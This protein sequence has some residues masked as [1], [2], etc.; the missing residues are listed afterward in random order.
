MKVTLKQTCSFFG[1]DYKA[2]SHELPDSVGKEWFFKALVK[3]GLAEIIDA[4]ASEQSAKSAP[5]AAASDLRPSEAA[6]KATEE[7]EDEIIEDNEEVEDF[8]DEP[9]EKSAPVKA[10]KKLKKSSKK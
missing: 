2:G 4:K 10:K 9:E 6:V 5:L 1:K 3:G 7:R 8:L